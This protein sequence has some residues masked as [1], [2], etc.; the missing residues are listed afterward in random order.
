MEL[1]LVFLPLQIYFHNV[2]IKCEEVIESLTSILLNTLVWTGCHGCAD[3]RSQ[4]GFG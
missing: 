2:T 3:E 1:A 4:A